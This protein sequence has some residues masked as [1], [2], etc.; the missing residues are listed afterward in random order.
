MARCVQTYHSHFGILTNSLVFSWN[1]LLVLM[2]VAAT[3]SGNRPTLWFV[4]AGWN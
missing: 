1:E 3:L 2:S 4:G